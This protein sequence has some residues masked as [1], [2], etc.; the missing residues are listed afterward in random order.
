MEKGR[1]RKDNIGL[2]EVTSSGYSSEQPRTEIRLYRKIDLH[3]LSFS[4]NGGRR[5][6]NKDFER[7]LGFVMVEYR[8]LSTFV[9]RRLNTDLKDFTFD[10]WKKRGI[11]KTVKICSG[12]IGLREVNIGLREVNIDLREVRFIAPRLYRMCYT[13]TIVHMESLFANSKTYIH[14]QEVNIYLREVQWLTVY[15]L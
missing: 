13:G 14:L 10:L 7:L 8:V 3:S 12:N 9:S 1:L 5:R 2:R 11:M 4:S 6:G 15:I